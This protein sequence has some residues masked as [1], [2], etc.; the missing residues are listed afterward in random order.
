VSVVEQVIGPHPG[1]Q[2]DFLATE[3]DLA[4][5][6]GKAGTGKALRI[7]EPIPT[8]TGW[9]AMGDLVEGDVV[10]DETGAPTRV[11][12]AHPVQMAADAYRLTFDDGTTIECN[13]EHLWLTYD[14][15][16]LRRLRWST[17]E[18][19]SR[20]RAK[21]PSRTSGRKSEKFAASLAARNTA[22][23]L[24][25]EAKQATGTVRST[26]D[27]VRTLLTDRGRTNHAVPVS[28]PLSLPAADLPLDPYLLGVWLGDGT[29]ANGGITTA[30][31]EI[32]E[33]FTRLGWVPG[34]RKLVR[35]TVMQLF[36]GFGTRLRKMGLLGAKRIPVEYLRGSIEQRIELLKGLM[37]TDGT[38]SKFGNCVFD[39][40]RPE[41]RDGFAELLAS[42]GIRFGM[43]PRDAKLYGRITSRS[44]RFHF[45]PPFVV[46]KL[47]RKASR[48]RLA[49]R[50]TCSFRYIV[51]A[52]RVETSPMRCI[53]VANPR[54]LFLAGRAMLV[55][56]NTFVLAFDPLRWS[57]VPGFR[58]LYVRKDSGRFGELW[59]RMTEL[60][61]LRS[62]MGALSDLRWRFPGGARITLT[63]LRS[64][65]D[66][67]A[68]RGQAYAAIYFDEVTEIGEREFWFL[69][70]RNRT[71]IPGF[72]PYVRC[73]CNPQASGWV[74]TLLDW[75][76]GKDGY[77][78]A[79]RVGKL[80]WFARDSSD[81]LVWGDTRDEVIAKL[82][83][84]SPMSVTFIPG[85][86]RVAELDAEYEAKLKAMHRTLRAQLEKGNWN[87]REAKG[88]YFHRDEFRI[89]PFAM[90]QL[91]RVVRR[92]RA[93]DLAASAPSGTNPDPDWTRGV[94]LAW[95]DAKNLIIE[96][97]VELRAGPGDVEAFI[98]RAAQRD[99]EAIEQAAWLGRREVPVEVAL[100][101]DP[102]QAGKAQIRT[103]SER[104][105]GH[106]VNTVPA[107]QDKETMARVWSPWVQQG[108]VYV[109]QGPWNES[110]LGE[111]ED[112]PFGAFDDWI[113]AVSCGVQVLTSKVAPRSVTIRGA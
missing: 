94:K 75:W 32:I 3:A 10:F 34:Y 90:P 4:F 105:S 84:S 100:F 103:M 1:P 95:T 55:T 77:P 24:A 104:L 47:D 5:F 22:R 14:Y 98:V 73:T 57:H 113:D 82:P 30:D 11:V 76:I 37:D 61:P 81:V 12:E 63:H 85:A 60:Y 58:A 68:H 80:R 59:D 67:E 56:H 101:Q 13:G 18:W 74:R 19:R 83:G 46:F 107:R 91:G 111:A 70:S 2:M 99:A 109:V 66:A 15:T 88:S 17:D 29:E 40:T 6:G 9:K 42:L 28:G 35:T 78:V 64:M 62:G 23:A 36:Y 96:D 8:P 38:T 27:I 26:A 39:T 25:T 33:S 89:V 93:W 72:R 69:I 48:Q 7:D 112:F 102:G 110:F 86:E 20:R 53:R 108:R 106:I 52:E 41:L 97:G 16:E 43:A 92:V 49:S 71:N 87:A 51:R 21:R 79:E 54:G 50:Q 45:T 65:A 44:Y 31:P